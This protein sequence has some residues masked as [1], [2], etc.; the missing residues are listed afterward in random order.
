MPE[1][2]QR[3]YAYGKGLERTSGGERG[4]KRK[5]VGGGS[6]FPAKPSGKDGQFEKTIGSQTKRTS[7]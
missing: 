1:L 4:M 7:F 2:H 3:V 6:K 5:S